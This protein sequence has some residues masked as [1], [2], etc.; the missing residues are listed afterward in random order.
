VRLACILTWVLGGLTALA[1]LVVLVVLVASRDRLLELL[2]DSPRWDSGYD[3]DTI[4]AL[5]GVMSVVVVVWCAVAAVLAVL[6]WR[7][8]RGAW[9]ALVVSAVLAAL[10]AAVAFP[11]SIVHLAVTA[12]SAGMLTSR[13]TRE[14]FVR[15]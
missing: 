7:G 10:V 5:A 11:F 9:I 3:D 4:V 1:Y 13:P 12:S 8:V 15:R 6:T 2:H 14:W